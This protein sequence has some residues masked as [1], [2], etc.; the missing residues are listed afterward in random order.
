MLPGADVVSR[1]RFPE[2]QPGKVLWWMGPYT[3]PGSSQPAPHAVASDEET[4][5]ADRIGGLLAEERQALVAPLEVSALRSSH[6]G[7]W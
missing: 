6:G 2:I 4:L 5:D 1:A 7:W 3:R